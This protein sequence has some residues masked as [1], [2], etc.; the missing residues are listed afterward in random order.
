MGGLT[1]RPPEASAGDAAATSQRDSMDTGSNSFAWDL[2]LFSEQQ[3][4]CFEEFYVRE[5][6]QR[7][8]IFLALSG[9]CCAALGIVQLSD[10]DWAAGSALLAM[11]LVFA[12]MLA[13]AACRGSQQQSQ[14]KLISYC[15][16]IVLLG[17]CLVVPFLSESLR[18]DPPLLLL[19]VVI[20]IY[21]LS[22]L[23]AVFVIVLCLATSIV[24]AIIALE[25]EKY[26]ALDSRY[27]A[28]RRT[29]LWGYIYCLPLA[30]ANILGIY[31]C[32]HHEHEQIVA[33]QL[34]RK[35][36]QER[37]E[38]E[39]KKQFS[40]FVLSAAMPDEAVQWLTDHSQEAS[41][42][43]AVMHNMYLEMT[44]QAS[45]LFC[46][47]VGF[48]KI[49]SCCS[50]KKLVGTLNDIFGEF[51][52]IAAR[53]HCEK[54]KILGDCYYC[55]AG[56]I[57]PR[58]D[59]ARCCV[60][61][62]LELIEKLREYEDALPEPIQMRVGIHTGSV[63]S[64]V[65]G[66]RNYQYD[67]WSKTVTIA[68]LL[69]QTSLPG[70]IHISEATYACLGNEY[71][72][73]P[74][75]EAG[76]E[77]PTV[78]KNMS[79]FFVQARHDES[80]T[81]NDEL[82]TI[83]DSIATNNSG[84]VTQGDIYRFLHRTNNP[85]SITDIVTMFEDY[86]LSTDGEIDFHTFKSAMQR[87]NDVATSPLIAF[88]KHKF[89]LT[90]KDRSKAFFIA[91]RNFLRAK[92]ALAN[93]GSLLKPPRYFHP[94]TLRFSDND[95]ENMFAIHRASSGGMFVLIDA[96]MYF[97]T[98]LA[99][100]VMGEQAT[101]GDCTKVQGS[102]LGAVCVAQA[103]IVLNVICTW[104]GCARPSKSGN[105]FWIIS[106]VTLLLT[107]CHA[108]V[109]LKCQDEPACCGRIL[110]SNFVAECHNFEDTCT[111]A[112]CQAG[113]FLCNDDPV[114]ELTLL[115]FVS[116]LLI[117]ACST[118]LYGVAKSAVALVVVLFFIIY[119]LVFAMDENFTQLE[120]FTPG[121]RM[122]VYL[123]LLWFV[124]AFAARQ[125][126]F[127]EREAFR[128]R[129]LAEK[130]ITEAVALCSKYDATLRNIL[131]DHV[132]DRISHEPGKMIAEQ[133]HAAIIFAHVVNYEDFY[134]EDFNAGLDCIRILNELICKFDDLVDL[135]KYAPLT[136]IKTIGS[137]YMAA[138]GLAEV[139][140]DVSN[141]TIAVDFAI[142]MFRAIRSFNRNLFNHGFVLRVG[143]HQG[144]VVAGV[145]GIERLYYDVWG[146]TVNVASRME[147][148]GVN[149]GIQVTAGIHDELAGMY[150]F[151][152][153]RATAVKGKLEPLT[154]YFVLA[155]QD[156]SE[157]YLAS[158]EFQPRTRGSFS[159]E[160]GS[161]NEEAGGS[162][163]EPA[164]PSTT[165]Q[166]GAHGAGSTEDT[167]A[168]NLTILD[169]DL[170]RRTFDEMP[171][172]LLPESADPSTDK[173]GNLRSDEPEHS[174]PDARLE[175]IDFTFME[176]SI[177]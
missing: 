163:P 103:V 21:I 170:Q 1:S 167:P 77:R 169:L 83:Y 39:E 93:E 105:L 104:R 152:N 69:E 67:I 5:A 30:L 102:L 115:S 32:L 121:A 97:L 141:A 90:D 75:F 58:R 135:P 10:A 94:V 162:P 124:M 16:V 72:C 46:D 111:I 57:V 107:F 174:A 85:V 27:G 148:S 156:D 2:L 48:T 55:A 31:Y 117:L 13:A 43:N 18:H 120:D 150:V 154:T 128:R 68:N 95:T 177:I 159:S 14:H 127:T 7:S 3:R 106:L 176:E 101:G 37:E 81:D 4:Q 164:S 29:E 133:R 158:H 166:G 151:S 113:F 89:Q 98:N 84:K 62:A 173:G 132:A 78:L 175:L 86:E 73:V 20:T 36:V 108:L 139:R 52:R 100:F 35:L 23:R 114:P 19:I 145:I 22:S 144:P 47:I 126:E 153:P 42:G 33:F 64:G 17:L 130:D 70:C 45:V 92:A 71:R 110:G 66:R 54:I 116:G 63:L 34:L 74:R 56:L 146:D 38:A 15:V 147:S 134:S 25:F 125:S 79:T 88:I 24:H 41:P 129:Q 28:S 91:F 118:M 82:R 99:I 165:A 142:D 8:L 131:P 136:K 140:D 50:A 11:G 109:S 49:S 112:P 123:M 26:A 6:W 171:L 160:E 65:L 122:P 80:S 138:V 53:H 40:Q 143:I 59:H 60:E 137:T 149:G 168:S 87:K 161:D 12:A 9:I 155:R 157:R 172:E 51:D 61:M 96:L 44:P 119:V 76:A